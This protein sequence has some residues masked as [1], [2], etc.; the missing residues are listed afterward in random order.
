MERALLRDEN[1]RGFVEPL[2]IDMERDLAV[3]TTKSSNTENVTTANPENI[4]SSFQNTQKGDNYLMLMNE[5]L[6]KTPLELDISQGPCVIS[7][8]HT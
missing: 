8:N 1:K 7:V 3:S 6:R 2:R 5:R 4:E